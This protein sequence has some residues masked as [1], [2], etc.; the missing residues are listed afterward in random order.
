MARQIDWIIERLA[1][2]PVRVCS[3]I[4]G[5]LQRKVQEMDKAGILIGLSGGLDS[6]VAAYLSV[7]AVGKEK[8]SRFGDPQFADPAHGDFG[9]RPGS[10]AS[11]LGIEPL[12]TSKM[13]RVNDGSS[14]LSDQ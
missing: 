2:D 7:R 12:N 1:I 9:F 13:G 11:A 4:E 10:P 8:A 5:L 3:Q 6:A 14:H